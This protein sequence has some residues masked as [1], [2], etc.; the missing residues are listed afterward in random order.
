MPLPLEQGADNPPDNASLENF[1]GLSVPGTENHPHISLG[2]D[3]GGF[4]P[5]A[6]GP[7]I[8]FDI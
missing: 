8:A 2:E 7:L 6:M 5:I 3:S 1:G 4:S